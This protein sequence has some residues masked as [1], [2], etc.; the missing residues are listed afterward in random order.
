[1]AALKSDRVQ[2]LSLFRGSH[3]AIENLGIKLRFFTPKVASSVMVVY[4]ASRAKNRDA[5]AR[6]L[7]GMIMST[8]FI[9][10]SPAAGVRAFWKLF[11]KPTSNEEKELR[12]GERLITRAQELWKP[13][14]SPGPY[15]EMNDKTW[16]DLL[17]F[18]GPSFEF[19]RGKIKDV[20]TTSLIGDANKADIT[21]AI[22]MARAD[23]P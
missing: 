17:D 16:L 18:I 22:E 5:I 21:K 15:G 9:E 6:S 10:T 19:G 2:A 12:D 14:G 23:K 8:V 13:L 3:T 1:M 11:G 20:Y 4:D 7:Q